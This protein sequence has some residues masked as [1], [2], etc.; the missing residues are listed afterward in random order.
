MIQKKNLR[1]ITIIENSTATAE[2]LREW[3]FSAL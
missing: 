1:I 2:T 3:G